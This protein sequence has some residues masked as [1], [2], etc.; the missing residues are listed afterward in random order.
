MAGMPQ[1]AMALW[2]LVDGDTNSKDTNGTFIG[3]IL[4]SDLLHD[5]PII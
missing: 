5:D 2:W 1:W 3:T 4:I